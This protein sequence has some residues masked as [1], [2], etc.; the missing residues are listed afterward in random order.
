MSKE[1]GIMESKLG[2]V[3]QSNPRA[4]PENSEEAIL[5]HNLLQMRS[6]MMR[7]LM[8][9]SMG[10]NAGTVQIG[11]KPFSCAAA[12]GFADAS[13]GKIMAF[14]N[15]QD[16]PESIRSVYPQFVFRIAVGFE[17]G[18]LLLRVLECSS[19]DSFSSQAKVMLERT[20]ERWNSTSAVGR[21]A[22]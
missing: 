7:V 19:G 12:R 6:S 1:R 8:D 17:P 21:R 15:Y 22:A 2:I 11:G 10:G 5:S 3:H 20:M 4:L 18:N 16:V 14:G 9:E 13:S